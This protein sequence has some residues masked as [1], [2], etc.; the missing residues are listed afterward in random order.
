VKTFLSSLFKP[1][2][3]NS[4]IH[5]VLFRFVSVSL[6]SFLID[7]GLFVLCYLVSNLLLPSLVI[8]RVI[9]SSINF[10]LNKKFTFQHNGTFW[11]SLAKY[12]GLCLCVFALS[13]YVLEWLIIF[14]INVFLAK[15]L[16]DGFIFLLSFL[17]QR[18]FI[19][20]RSLKAKVDT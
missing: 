9:S 3:N 18:F 20:S 19:F 15:I 5:F 8:A 4:A 1:L 11:Q 12:Y 17:T 10:F 14:K 13:F 16:A 7:Y 6:V 2:L